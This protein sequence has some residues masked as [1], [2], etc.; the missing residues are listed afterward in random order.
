M[1]SSKSLTSKKPGSSLLSEVLQ[2]S[3]SFSPNE[4]KLIGMW[5]YSRPENTQRSNK[6]ELAKFFSMFPDL[7]LEQI[8]TF[9][10]IQFLNAIKTDGL[11]DTSINHARDTLSSLFNFL[12]KSHYIEKNPVTPVQ[13]K[14]TADQT[15]HKIQTFEETKKMIAMEPLRRNQ[16]LI[17]LIFETG[18]RAGE[19]CKLEFRHIYKQGRHWYVVATGKGTKTRSV[20]ISETLRGQFL[21][22]IEN[23]DGSSCFDSDPIF[24]SLRRPYKRLTGT[25]IYRII[26]AASTRAGRKRTPHEGRHGHATTALERG[27]DLREIQ[28]TLGH[29]SIVTTTKYTHVRPSQSTSRLINFDEDMD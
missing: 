9:H 28:M 26:V 22:L 17:R 29:E 27:A 5:L 18:M 19:V 11:N 13:R 16:V 8:E 3:M 24:R 15:A 12:V 4:I 20:M 7:S 6:N 2:G 23:Q 1:G 25:D 10:V 21:E 14:K